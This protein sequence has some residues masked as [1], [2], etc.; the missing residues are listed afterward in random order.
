MQAKFEV[1]IG[2]INARDNYD[3]MHHL[4]AV[5]LVNMIAEGGYLRSRGGST[6]QT[7]DSA[8][9]SGGYTKKTLANF[10]GG[11][12]EKL[13]A[14]FNDGT[15]G[16]SLYDVTTT[17]VKLS[18]SFSSS[19]WSHMMANGRLIL[20]NGSDSPQVWDGGAT[21]SDITIALFDGGG[22]PHP[23]YTKSDLWGCTMHQNRAYYWV[24]NSQSF[25]YT[26]VSGAYQGDCIE[27]DLSFVVK[28]GGYLVN[29]LS[30][31]MDTGSGLNDI[32][33]FVFSTGECVVYEGQD[34]GTSY[35]W[36][37]V[38][39]FNIGRP[40]DI[41]ATTKWGGDNII[42]TSS[43]VVSIDEIL[44]FGHVVVEQPTIWNKIVD[45]A[46]GYYKKYFDNGGWDMYFSNSTS[47][48]I[49][50]FKQK[51]NQ[52][53]QLVLNTKRGTWCEFKGL[54]AFTWADHNNSIYFGGDDSSPHI[55][56]AETGVSD[57]GSYIEMKCITAF[58]DY[59]HP[60]WKQLT[61]VAL[62]T[63]YR[64]DL[65]VDALVDNAR[66]QDTAIDTPNEYASSKWN[67]GK[68]NSFSWGGG[69]PND[70]L[71]DDPNTRIFPCHGK[72]YT[73]ALKFRAM[74]KAQQIIWYFYK[75]TMRKGGDK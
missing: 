38:N 51:N 70:A 35:D 67:A 64:R 13:L 73:L 10:D 63:N 2:G 47:L 6:I 57:S 65:R 60:G 37:L 71:D 68:W 16:H 33:V 5:S 39:R 25:F 45:K 40:V 75:L 8:L 52:Y 42:L 15:N 24:E 72:G 30:Q 54:D 58:Q 43:G 12:T 74:S 26:D 56:Q 62:C 19:V 3:S 59:G 22:S 11:G 28:Q 53:R 66:S 32:A 36:G 20:C 27:F 4:D 17:P 18:D 1:P 48:L 21:T 69:D 50:N 41:R 49:I 46:Q 55:F 61:R 23:T 44:K 7:N 14:G 29:I 9:L 31:S 34:P